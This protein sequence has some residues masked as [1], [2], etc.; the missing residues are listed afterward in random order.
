MDDKRSFSYGHGKSVGHKRSSSFQLDNG[1]HKRQNFSHNSVTSKPIDTIYRILCPAKRIGSVLGKGGDIINALR[2]ETHAKIRVADAIPGFEDRVI[3]IFSYL[4]KES[5]NNDSDP[6]PENGYPAEEEREEMHPDCPAQ[7]A[8][9]KV[10]DRI[11]ADEYIRGG[12]LYEK[13]ERDHEDVIARILVPNNQVGCLLGKGGTVIQKLRSETRA[14]IRILPAEHL[15]PCA[16]RTDEL[17][18]ISGMPHVVKRALY[19]ISS[20]LHRHPRKENPPLEDLIFASTNGLYTPG[21][22]LPPP[23]S[24]ENQGWSHKRPGLHETPMPRFGGFINKSPGY[25]SGGYDN[26]RAGD[27]HDLLDEFSMR[28]LCAT[29]KVGGLIGKGGVNVRQLEQHTGA[30]IQVE[31][32]DPEADERVVFV[33]SK[34]ASWDRNSPTIV[35]ILQ[36]Q[37]KIS[38]TSEKGTIT[39]R[40]L[41]PSSKVGCLLGQGGNIITE[42]RMRTRADIRVYSKNDKPKYIPSNE[43]LIQISGTNT[44]AKEALIEIASR[45]RERTLRSSTNPVPHGSFHRI[46][47][48]DDFD[49]R[50]VPS[51]SMVRARTTASYRLPKR[52]SGLPYEAHECPGS[53]TPAGY[54]ETMSAAGYQSSVSADGYRSP[55]SVSRYAGPADSV[56]YGPSSAA[57]YL[58][59]VSADGRPSHANVSAYPGPASAT[60]YPDPASATRYPDPVSG[61]RYPDPASAT[62]YP[63]PVSG[64]RYPG[65]ASA[66][67]YPGPPSAAGYHNAP[68]PTAYDGP[69][70]STRYSMN[71]SVEIKIPKGAAPTVLG[72]GGSNIS[73]ISQ[74][75]GARM[76]LREPLSGASECVIEI[77][78]SSDQIKAAQSLLQ[79][80]MA[81]GGRDAPPPTYVP[82]SF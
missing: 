54:P 8:L 2:E 29:E 40:L 19:E 36:L 59:S 53:L 30:H 46:T 7:D 69:L 47:A 37:D 61:A 21:P 64:A 75:S 82:R 35:A 11:T 33:S 63:D 79:A 44:V 6:E 32:T 58:S 14:S 17:V 81:S 76:Q 50:A 16:M 55:A 78:G 28:I 3:I 42:M 74:I 41:V 72:V 24:Q 1:K 65:P 9:L 60:R 49:S 20:L 73:E 23:M 12:E 45:L 4:S 62:R 18:Q 26:G 68:I 71:N 10:H 31:D 77:R 38:G 57:G 34:E 80:F 67:W 48:F 25:A 22:P 43:E 5:D 52:D 66:A 56:G 70:R 15:P 51:S 13:A 27:S 39:T